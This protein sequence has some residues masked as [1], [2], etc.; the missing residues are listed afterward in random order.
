[1]VSKATEAGGA[2]DLW[3]SKAV[4]RESTFPHASSARPYHFGKSERKAS[5]GDCVAPLE[6]QDGKIAEELINEGVKPATD[7]IKRWKHV[8][9]GERPPVRRGTINA[10]R[11]QKTLDAVDIEEEEL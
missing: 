3:L 6:G 5:M 2:Y 10:T 4:R 8:T 9:F 11:S 7:M 1:M